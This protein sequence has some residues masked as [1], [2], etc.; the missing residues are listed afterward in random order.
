ML[1]TSLHP[2]VFVLLAANFTD[3]DLSE[4]VLDTILEAGDMLYFPRGY[5]HQVHLM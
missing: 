2:V 4:P 1:D 3:A 5:P